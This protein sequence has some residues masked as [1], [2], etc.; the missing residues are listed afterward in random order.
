MSLILT[1]TVPTS[2]FIIHNSLFMSVIRIVV[3]LMMVVAVVMMVAFGRT[4]RIIRLSTPRLPMIA[5]AAL[6]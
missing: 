4:G 5:A 1:I 6:P 2:Q 3:M